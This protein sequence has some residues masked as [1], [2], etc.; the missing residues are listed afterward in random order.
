MMGPVLDET[1]RVKKLRYEKVKESGS[2]HL[3]DLP[4]SQS[5]DY[6]RRTN[7]TTPPPPLPPRNIIKKRELEGSFESPRSL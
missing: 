2:S 7:E 6:G 1:Q 5:F 4:V 3:N